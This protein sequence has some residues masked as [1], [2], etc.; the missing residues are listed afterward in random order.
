M[1]E[2]Y[3]FEDVLEAYNSRVHGSMQCDATDEQV[4]HV[5]SSVGFSDGELDGED[6]PAIDD[7]LGGTAYG[8]GIHNPMIVVEAVPYQILRGGE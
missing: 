7:G 2:A 5:H 1:K 8:R 3:G 6:T 4:H